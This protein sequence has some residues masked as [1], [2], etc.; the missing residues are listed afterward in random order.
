MAEILPVLLTPRRCHRGPAGLAG[1]W[2]LVMADL[3]RAA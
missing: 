2:L 3:R 1:V